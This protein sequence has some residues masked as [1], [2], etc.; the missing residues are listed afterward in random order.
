MCVMGIFKCTVTS[1]KAVG[2]PPSKVALDGAALRPTASMGRDY[3]KTKE[4]IAEMERRIV[5]LSSR[6]RQYGY[7]RYAQALGLSTSDIQK[8]L[9]GSRPI[10]DRYLEVE[11]PST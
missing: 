8:M 10:R 9:E 3:M 2:F 11:C 6:L 5:I 7:R 1:I 4:E